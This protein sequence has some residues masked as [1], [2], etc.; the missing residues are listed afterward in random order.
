[1]TNCHPYFGHLD[2]R[3]Q[4]VKPTLIKVGFFF[5]LGRIVYPGVGK[6][7]VIYAWSFAHCG[8]Y[9]GSDTEVQSLPSMIAGNNRLSCNLIPRDG[10][11]VQGS[12]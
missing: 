2:G 10:L 9:E 12:R 7:K 3:E 8:G 6:V 1:V 4:I 11:V 5:P